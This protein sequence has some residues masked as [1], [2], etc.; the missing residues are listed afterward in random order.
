MKSDLRSSGVLAIIPARGGSKGIPCKNIKRLNGKPLLAY[1]IEHA[2]HTSAI[3]RV[4]VSTDDSSV[5]A[6]AGE[7]Q[8]Q[9]IWR[10]PEISHDAAESE[11]ALLHSLEYLRKTEEYEPE[12]VVFLQATSP[13][14]AP[15]DIGNAI[16]TLEREQADSLFSAS[17]VHGFVWRR[18]G[19]RL[20]S[21]TY[22]YRHRQRRQDAPQDLIENGSIYVFKPWVLREFNNRLG[23]KIAV[24]QMSVLDSFQVDTPEDLEVIEQLMALRRTDPHEVDWSSVN[25]LVLDFDGVMT[26]NRVLVDEHGTESV[27]CHRGDGWGLERLKKAGVEVIVLSTESNEV[28]QARCGKL[29]IPVIQDCRD[30]LRTLQEVARQRC[31]K[32]EQIAYVGN[33]IND[34]E[35][36]KWVGLPVAVADARPEVRAN[37]RIVTSFPGGAGAVREVCDLISSSDRTTQLE[38]LSEA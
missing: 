26:D 5:G 23:G 6:V 34:L 20:S 32:P 28:V 2:R 27:W 22:D 3:N 19:E 35:C 8:A 31:L 9:V 7:F 25:L 14:R 38:T 18:E 29:G 21:L 17:P 16:E 30:K 15:N 4:V 12:L 10:P 33:D 24:Y 11:S 36:M 37:A 13:L 1:S